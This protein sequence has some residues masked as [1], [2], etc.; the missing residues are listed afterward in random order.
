MAILLT[1]VLS[2]TERSVLFNEVGKKKIE[3]IIYVKPTRDSVQ[4][5]DNEIAVY[6]TF[7]SFDQSNEEVE[8]DVKKKAKKLQ[9]RFPNNEIRIVEEILERIE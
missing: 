5:Y 7:A 2:Q 8:R 9:K 1:N 4:I 3:F 6:K